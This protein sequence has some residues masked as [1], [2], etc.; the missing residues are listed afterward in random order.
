M[1]WYI[2]E[3]A[4]LEWE[5]PGLSAEATKMSVRVI[6][7]STTRVTVR[8]SPETERGGPVGAVVAMIW[9]IFD[10]VEWHFNP[11]TGEQLPGTKFIYNAKLRKLRQTEN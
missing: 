7:V 5:M 2:G 11:D 6:M 9:S 1:N 10:D 3:V 4:E 8:S